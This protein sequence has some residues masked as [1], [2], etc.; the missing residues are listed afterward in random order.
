M[1]LLPSTITIHSGQQSTVA[2]QLSSVGLFAGSLTLSYGSLPQYASASFSSSSVSLTQGGTGT[3]T[4][5]LNTAAK[6]ASASVHS[7]PRPSTRLVPSIFAATVAI[8]LPFGAVRRKRL[9]RIYGLALAGLVIQGLVGCTNRYYEVNL[10]SPGTYQVPITAT[11]SNQ[12][13]ATSNLTVVVE[14]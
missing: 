6:T 13:S 8:L 1:T 14:P 12:N 3:T 2:V 11:D 10:V 7:P 9:A 4:L 5:T